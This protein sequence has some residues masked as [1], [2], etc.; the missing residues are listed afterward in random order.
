MVPI[1]V[2]KS[3]PTDVVIKTNDG[4]VLKFLKLTKIYKKGK[5]Y[6]YKIYFD[7]IKM[8]MLEGAIVDS[9]TGI[10]INTGVEGVTRTGGFEVTYHRDGMVMLKDVK[11]GVNF[12]R[13]KRTHINKLK[14][15]DKFFQIS[16][17]QLN[18]LTTFLLKNKDTPQVILNDYSSSDYV[19]CDFFMGGYRHKPTILI[20]PHAEQIFRDLF[21]FTLED[22]KNGIVIYIF[23]WRPSTIP[24]R[25]YLTIPSKSLK[26]RIEKIITAFRIG[27][28]GIVIKDF[29][30]ALL[31]WIARIV[32]K[33]LM[34]LRRK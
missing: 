25:T 22:M 28:G 33:I 5:L 15:P 11:Q 8:T 10:A 6:A 34:K 21:Q 18:N 19:T 3:F 7:G 32:A 26:L 20:L 24:H 31:F 29:Y 27:R 16:G 2:C 4:C 1:K 30:Y 13:E 12:V 23:F 9:V 17:L 14:R